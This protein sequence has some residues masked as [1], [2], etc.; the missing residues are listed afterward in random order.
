MIKIEDL[1]YDYLAITTEDE[2]DDVIK[3][4]EEYLALEERPLGVL[5]CRD[6]SKFDEEEIDQ[7]L[8]LIMIHN[9]IMNRPIR[10]IPEYAL[11]EDEALFVD[12]TDEKLIKKMHELSKKYNKYFEMAYA[13]REG[14]IEYAKRSQYS[15]V[16]G[17]HYA[18]ILQ[19]LG[20]KR[21]WHKD[22]WQQKE[23]YRKI[24]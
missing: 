7:L 19:S 15:Q 1:P 12:K 22:K 8:R 4:Y 16:R 5:S 23:T 24:R 13:I 9:A 6:G 18:S 11:R 14:F 20:W 21:G 2:L 3:K 10:F 17:Q